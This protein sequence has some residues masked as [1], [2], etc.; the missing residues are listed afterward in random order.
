MS[1]IVLFRAPNRTQIPVPLLLG[2]LRASYPPILTT[3]QT[4]ASGMTDPTRPDPTYLRLLLAKLSTRV[5]TASLS[6]TG[7][8]PSHLAFE[9]SS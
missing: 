3:P 8:F 2:R 5:S 4:P 7:F 1:A 6:N 9:L